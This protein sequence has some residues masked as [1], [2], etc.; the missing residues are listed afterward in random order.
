MSRRLGRTF[1]GSL[2]DYGRDYCKAKSVD[3][4]DEIK[5][6]TRKQAARRICYAN[7]L[8]VVSILPTGCADFVSQRTHIISTQVG[9][10]FG[11]GKLAA[12]ASDNVSSGVSTALQQSLSG[13][14]ALAKSLQERQ[15]QPISDQW[16][17]E[18]GW[19]CDTPYW[20]NTGCECTGSVGQRNSR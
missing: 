3:G 11:E 4:T 1:R 15:V 20:R 2:T 7:P 16:C 18:T 6:A 14:I 8:F 10:I 9:E 19:F 13:G 5:R 12:A 17:F